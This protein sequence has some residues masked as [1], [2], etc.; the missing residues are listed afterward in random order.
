[1]GAFK[2]QLFRIKKREPFPLAFCIFVRIEVQISTLQQQKQQGHSP[3]SSSSMDSSYPSITKI[4]RCQHQH[5]ININ[6]NSKDV[7][8]PRLLPSQPG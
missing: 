4:D 1:M 5:H 6:I 2:E 7:Y 3:S 8:R